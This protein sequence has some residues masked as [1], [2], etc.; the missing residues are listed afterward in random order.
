MERKYTE[1]E[2]HLNVTNNLIVLKDFRDNG[3]IGKFGFGE[4]SGKD[5]G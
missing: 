1:D 5:K 3:A 2:K 4:I